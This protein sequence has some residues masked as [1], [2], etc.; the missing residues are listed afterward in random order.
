MKAIVFDR[1]AEPDQ[2]LRLDDVSEPEPRA[3]EQLVRV[4]A[5]PIHPA[6]LSFIRGQYRIRPSLP[7]VA[8]L[9]GIGVVLGRGRTGQFAPG[10]RVAFRW[11]GSWAE[12]SAVPEHRLIPVPDD[13]P[14]AIACQISLN[15]LTAWGLLDEAEVE[16]GDWLLMTAG[17]ST[18]SNLVAAIARS[19]GIHTIGVV[20]GDAAQG[21]ARSAA[22][23]VFSAQDSRLLS[24]VAEVT[25]GGATALL[26]SVGGP[27]IPQLF[28]ALKAGARI[29]AYGVQDREPAAVTNAMLIY[30]NLT[31]KGFG[32]DRWLAT[33]PPGTLPS[34][35]AGLWA[36]IRQGALSLPIDSTFALSAF[37]EA[38]AADGRRGRQGKV[39]LT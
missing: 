31:W 11:P 14:D 20:R 33:R 35:I 15:P 28:P 10:T 19:R 17:A 22:Q 2:V 6:D 5:R 30:N 36:L 1:A 21:A 24:R 39:L 8:G 12:V 37:R 16:P 7:Q 23:H 9:E 25:G 13:V 29:I 18:V 3:D 38:L 27:F 4:T 34:V 32:I 26:D